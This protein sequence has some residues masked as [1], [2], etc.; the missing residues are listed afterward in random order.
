MLHCRRQGK[1]YTQRFTR[2]APA[3]TLAERVLP[4]RQADQRGT[5]VRFLY[6]STIFAPGVTID[7][8]TIRSRLRELAFLNSA[9]TIHCQVID[10]SRKGSN[11]ST[12]GSSNGAQPDW[13]EFHFSGGL[14]EYVQYN[15]RD[16][17][18]MHEPIYIKREASLWPSHFSQTCFA[19][20]P[21]STY[22]YDFT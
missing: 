4:T 16:K 20:C 9:A 12:N 22:S 8:D 18:A 17:H 11:S 3:G 19:H 6:D 13:E 7:A 15:N 5:Q 2:G 14:K 1:E 21:F 10:S